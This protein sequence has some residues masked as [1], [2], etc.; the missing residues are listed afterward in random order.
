[1]GFHVWMRGSAA[2]FSGI[3]CG[4]RRYREAEAREAYVT[5]CAAL[6]STLFAESSSAAVH[7]P[8]FKVKE[9]IPDQSTYVEY[10]QRPERE[11]GEVLQEWQQ[12]RDNVLE[13]LQDARDVRLN[14]SYRGSRSS[15]PGQGEFGWVGGGLWVG[16]WLVGWV[17]GEM[18]LWKVLYEFETEVTQRSMKIRNNVV[19]ICSCDE[20]ALPWCMYN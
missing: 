16:G 1:M 10:Y 12:E 13:A 5:Q 20:S 14:G 8:G 7:L 18:E 19:V 6:C 4:A 11:T 15:E 9:T 3:R 17:S 2:G